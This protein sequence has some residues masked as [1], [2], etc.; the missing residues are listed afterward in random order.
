MSER[1]QESW[2]QSGRGGSLSVHVSEMPAERVELRGAVPFAELDTAEDEVTRLPWPV[3]YRL[4]L[5]QVGEDL[6]VS[7]RLNASVELMCDRCAEF[8]RHEL[9]TEDVCH[10]YE[11]VAGEVVDLTEGLREDILV[12]FPQTHLCSEDCAG[13]C[14]RCGA[15]LN[16]GPC[17]CPEEPES[18]ESGE[19]EEGRENP[20]SVLDGLEL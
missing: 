16:E 10:R 12:A 2:G 19:R 1:Q 18:S 6:L 8:S 14:P 7:G 20:F 5:S 15:N 13:L 11:N 3:S 9:S 17:G 4:H